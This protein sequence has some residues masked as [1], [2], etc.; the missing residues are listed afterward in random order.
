MSDLLY[1]NLPVGVRSSSDG[2]RVEF[3]VTINGGFVAFGAVAKNA[4]DDDLAEA[5]QQAQE[6]QQQQ[7]Q[8]NQQG[9]VTQQTTPQ[10]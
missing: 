7:A 4:F 6:R 10:Q 1:D 8:Q 2:N 3:G 5:Q 9:Q